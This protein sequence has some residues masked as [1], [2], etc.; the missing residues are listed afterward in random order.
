MKAIS[1]TQKAASAR[2]PRDH[3]YRIAYP[4]IE[5]IRSVTDGGMPTLSG[6]FAVFREWTEIDSI[7]EGNFME[8]FAPGAFKRTIQINA[9]RMRVL[10][11]HGR[12]PQIGNKPLGPIA[13]LREDKQ[14]AYYEAPML[15]TSYNRDL[16]PGLE[17]GLYG[18][19]M[20]FRVI[21]EEL[22]EEPG[23]SAYNE[24]G[25][26]ERVVTEAEVLEFGPVTFPQ[27]AGATAGVRSITDD[28]IMGQYLNN[29]ERLR[30]L[31]AANLPEGAIHALLERVEVPHSPSGAAPE[32][33]NGESREPVRQLAVYRNPNKK[34]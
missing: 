9:E 34:K 5:L 4:G 28:I 19:S 15:D 22:N 23:R 24:N 12:D 6:H 18:A 16:I 32:D 13:T 21:K 14:G 25:I 8:Q 31:L 2:P 20:R 7:F 29:P 30:D 11:Q 1:P 33:G 27:Y 10:F 26:P 3:L 17:K